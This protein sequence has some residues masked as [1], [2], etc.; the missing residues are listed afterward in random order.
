MGCRQ[1]KAD[2]LTEH[3]DTEV[4][5]NDEIKPSLDMSDEH[6]THAQKTMLRDTWTVVHNENHGIE[7]FLLIFQ[8]NPSAKSV[9]PFKD[10]EG[11][12]LLENHSFIAHAK[13]FMSAI[14]STIRNLD[15]LDVVL[16]PILHKLGEIHGWIPRFSEEYLPVFIDAI[17]D[18]ITKNIGAKCDERVRE[19]WH[20]L[21]HFI[22]H[23]LI[24]G[25]TRAQKRETSLHQHTMSNGTT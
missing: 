3:L 11:R 22:S 25:Y 7:I 4:L 16:I 15:S 23:K 14:D 1:S 10:L 17:I 9:F 8:R 19:A 18:V 12:E 6:F 2:L 21:G 24:D 13:R 5:T 20:H